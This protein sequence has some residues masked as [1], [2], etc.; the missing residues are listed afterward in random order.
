MKPTVT[1]VDPQGKNVEV[2][3]EQVIP[4]MRSGFGA[5]AGQTVT[6]ADAAGTQIPIE[7]LAEGLS[8]GERLRLQ[9]SE[10]LFKKGAEER[11]GGAAGLGAGLAY[12]ALQGASLGT[13]G[14]ALIE[15][16]LV[17]PDTLAQLE[18]AR[19]GG[20][21]STVGA[22]EALGGLGVAAL[23]GGFGAGAAAEGAAARTLG[24]NM[25]RG[26]GR[27]ALIGAGY[28][29]G[30][31]LTQ[32]GIEGRE[33][34]LLPAAAGGAVLG[35]ALGA[36]GEGF[37]GKAT[38]LKAKGA[39]AA[40][41]KAAEEAAAREAGV[42]ATDVADT[43]A[44]TAARDTLAGRYDAIKTQA[45][46]L[47]DEAK[48][49]SEAWNKTTAQ[50]LEKTGNADLDGALKRINKEI[51]AGYKDVQKLS[52]DIRTI[53]DIEV[54][55]KS[56]SDT[57]ER[58]L[59]NKSNL[60]DHKASI[61]E[62]YSLAKAEYDATKA[63]GADTIK[64]AAALSKMNKLENQLGYILDA[65]KT[66]E[67]LGGLN[68]QLKGL[69]SNTKSASNMLSQAT[70]KAERI[71]ARLN[72]TGE[73]AAELA[74]SGAAAARDAEAVT[75]ADIERG[76]AERGAERIQ[77][78]AGGG[79]PTKGNSRFFYGVAEKAASGDNAAFRDVIKDM[80]AADVG[81]SQGGMRGSIFGEIVKRPTFLSQLTAE[82][83]AYLRGIAE[84]TKELKMIRTK[85]NF[86][87]V[88]RAAKA[89]A[90]IEQG[91]SPEAVAL[92]RSAGIEDVLS[93]GET[94]LRDGLNLV[95]KYRAAPSVENAAIADA[96]ETAAKSVVEAAP[97]K[98]AE[99]AAKAPAETIAALTP[100]E[101]VK[102]RQTL[103]DTEEKISLLEKE[104]DQFVQETLAK[105]KER[106]V[107]VEKLNTTKN[108]AKKSAIIEDLGNIDNMLET[109]KFVSENLSAARDNLA[110]QAANQRAMRSASAVDAAEQAENLAHANTALKEAKRAAKQGTLVERAGQ[111]VGKLTEKQAL[112]DDLLEIAKQRDEAADMINSLA[113][114]NQKWALTQGQLK[115]T[116]V[117]LGEEVIFKKQLEAFNR[118]PEAKALRAALEDVSK[119][120][121]K[122][123]ED[124]KTL[125]GILTADITQRIFGNGLLSMA[126]GAYMASRTAKSSM[127]KVAST[128]LNSAAFYNASS[129]AIENMAK[130]S[131]AYNRV[132]S[133][134]KGYTFSVPA[135]NAYIDGILADR[136]AADKAFDEMIRNGGVNAR[137]IEEARKRFNATV[138][139]LE[140]KRPPTTNGAEAQNFA[141]AVALIRNPSLL[142]KFVSDGALRQQDVDILQRVSPESYDQLKAAVEVLHQ[143][144][145]E[146]TMNLASLFKMSGKSKRSSM[147]SMTL[148]MSVLQQM[149]SGAPPQESGMVA[150]SETAAATGRASVKGENYSLE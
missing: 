128:M 129:K 110:E 113:A 1:L 55:E 86:T 80:I 10:T 143:K 102:L 22:G 32:A 140:R 82:N 6:L 62:Q 41:D 40:A 76:A 47:A 26:A 4:L 33:A 63:A 121:G 104:R 50:T 24:Q 38:S 28:G 79:G 89:L 99:A 43:E 108:E 96:G 7:S 100:E 109:R 131:M 141:R 54:F 142:T 77:Y 53:D 119:G 61:E 94:S 134:H 71:R 150:K 78:G 23:T 48:A 60:A 11:F 59:K 68:V 14:R 111:A 116:F 144:K 117:P 149:A 132:A 18:S 148:P 16:G 103:A 13:G 146:L 57:V 42:V 31:E 130:S 123:M 122:A 70:S 88:P 46:T 45:K 8:K 66:F 97:A 67:N 90:A 126:A 29:A 37:V 147:Y 69:A 84:N 145:P 65:E 136:G 27:E 98:A 17:N 9:S 133:G 124:P 105:T 51:D 52:S 72:G 95:E 115:N 5:R 21:F 19:G 106:N 92:A 25:L 107:L 83:A 35:G 101:T 114:S 87:R 138:D 75:L 85:G 74:G 12:G 120:A 30:S 49:A 139:Y 137:G 34:N 20:L 112:R 44:K 39:K 2:P 3:Q 58:G 127:A 64:T 73:K 118:T 93:V 135:A 125:Q 81:L 36:A 91:L 56:L 15:S